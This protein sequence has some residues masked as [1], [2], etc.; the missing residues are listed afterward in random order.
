MVATPPFLTPHCA[1]GGR[2]CSRLAGGETAQQ[3]PPFGEQEQQPL[4]RHPR[5]TLPRLFIPYSVTFSILFYSDYDYSGILSQIS[6][7]LVF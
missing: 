5:S 1:R 6:L 2:E 3:R 7:G 4:A